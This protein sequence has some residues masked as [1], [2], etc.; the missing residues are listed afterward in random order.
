MQCAEVAGQR[1][2]S[3]DEPGRHVHFARR[4]VADLDR[5]VSEA[6]S[7]LLGIVINSVCLITVGCRCS[8]S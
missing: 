1:R 2:E 6:N 5:E 8:Q 7:A 3:L 4:R